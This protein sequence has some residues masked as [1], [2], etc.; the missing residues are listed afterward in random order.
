MNMLEA[1]NE[2]KQA[3]TKSS[4]FVIFIQT[5]LS[6]KRKFLLLIHSNESRHRAPK[7]AGAPHA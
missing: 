3:K 4:L 6:D 1:G 7:I 5:L 2:I